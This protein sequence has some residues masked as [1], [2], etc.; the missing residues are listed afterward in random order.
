VTTIPDLKSSIRG[1][2]APILVHV[3]DHQELIFEAQALK[4]TRDLRT[5]MV[6]AAFALQKSPE[7]YSAHIA[8]QESSTLSQ[9]A[10][11]REREQFLAMCQPHIAA[12]LH[13]VDLRVKAPIVPDR[14]HEALRRHLDASQHRKP[15]KA[16]QEAVIATLLQRYLH[17]QP[18]LSMD[19]L[20]EQ[21]GAGLATVYL[22]ITRYQHCIER[23]TQGNRPFRLHSFSSNDWM[24]WIER[25]NRLSSVYFIDRSGTPRSATRLAKGLARL[26][27]DDLAIGGLMGAMHHL[28]AIDATAAP[29]LD[30]LLHGSPR[31]D[32]S[33]IEEIDPGLKLTKDPHDPAHVV[34]HFIDR[35]Q[36]LFERDNDHNW[37]ALP[38]CI[39]NMQR[40]R[41][42]HQV[43]DAIALIAQR[44]KQ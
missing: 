33:F 9:Y 38:D 11:Q 4:N 37:G 44:T 27:R 23:G 40:A 19:E 8:V 10:I 31:S 12:R 39:A 35:P 41:Q 25:S 5:L 20:V 34:V 32:L 42:T 16:S 28:P 29:H 1:Q 22:A 14:A 43:A 15:A 21:S 2:A 13:I 26:Q 6:E 36:S 17:G 30:I 18:G 24:Q 7:I 3:G